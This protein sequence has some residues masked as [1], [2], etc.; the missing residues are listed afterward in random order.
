MKDPRHSIFLW[1]AHSLK[2]KS[3]E[4]AVAE[5]KIVAKYT[6]IVGISIIALSLAGIILSH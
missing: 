3:R 5:V 4:D 1:R 2:K 6:A